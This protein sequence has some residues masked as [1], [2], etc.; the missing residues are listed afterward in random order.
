MFAINAIQTVARF[1]LVWF[2][3]SLGAA[4]AS[5]LVAPVSAEL[6]CSGAGAIKLLVKADSQAQDLAGDHA[7]MDCPLCA[8]HGAAPPLMSFQPEPPAPLAHALRPIPAARMA[9]LT[10]PPLPSRGP[11]AQT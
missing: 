4:I 11:P 5:P 10:A 7:S 9:A 2:A 8:S 3:L 6:V 1:V